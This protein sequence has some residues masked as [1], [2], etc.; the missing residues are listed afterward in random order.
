MTSSAW[1]VKLL[2]D[3]FEQRREEYDSGSIFVLIIGKASTSY[4]REALGEVLVEE[5]EWGCID[6]PGPVG[7][8][9]DLVTQDFLEENDCKPTLQALRELGS[10]KD[11]AG[12]LFPYLDGIFIAN[13]DSSTF[14]ERK[15]GLG[16]LV[17]LLKEADD[18]DYVG[19]V[20]Y[21]PG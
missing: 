6:P 9:G 14:E 4:D 13:V 10:E 16:A 11:V 3:P 12:E 15:H 19:I 5:D 1:Q 18:D 8:F 2:V 17:K 21:E 20:E 7:G